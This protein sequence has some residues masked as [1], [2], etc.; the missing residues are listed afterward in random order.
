MMDK[1]ELSPCPFCGDRMRHRGQ[2]F[3]HDD[4]DSACIL[5]PQAFV[6]TPERLAAWNR[7]ASY[8]QG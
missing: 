5:S 7:R 4:A 8:A 1:D 3:G 2:F 6:T